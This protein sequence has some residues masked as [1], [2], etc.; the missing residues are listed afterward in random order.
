MSCC[1]LW[2]SQSR[3][4][5]GL[6]IYGVS[7]VLPPTYSNIVSVSYSTLCFLPSLVLCSASTSLSLFCGT[8][9]SFSLFFFPYAPS[10]HHLVI[11]FHFQF[12]PLTHHLPLSSS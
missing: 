2:G 8:M 10:L 9:P 4:S 5:G 6:S 1:G 7:R 3:L 12:L 11:D